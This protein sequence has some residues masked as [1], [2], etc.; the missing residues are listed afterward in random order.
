VVATENKKNWLR[1]KASQIRFDL[2]TQNEY[3]KALERYTLYK[4]SKQGIEGALASDVLENIIKQ[5]Q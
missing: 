1:K 3:S 5:T 2:E 4:L